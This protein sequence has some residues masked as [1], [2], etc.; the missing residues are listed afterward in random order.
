MTTEA[1]ALRWLAQNTAARP[2]VFLV[3]EVPVDVLRA[4]DRSR[5]VLRLP[6]GIVALKSP[7]DDPDTVIRAVVWSIVEKLTGVYAPAVVERDS[8]VRLHLGRTDPGQEIRLRQTGQTRWQKEIV[9]GLVIRVERGDVTDSTE[10]RIGDARI[11][12][13][14][15]E[16]VLLSLPLNFLRG[17]GLRDVSV[18]LKSLML[19]H[20]AVVNAYR[21]NPRPVVLKRIADIAADVGND[22]L[23]DM[24]S[25]IVSA[26]QNVRIGRD[27]TGIGRELVIPAQVAAMATTNRPWLDRLSLMILESITQIDNV[28]AAAPPSRGGRNLPSLLEEARA[29][30][31]YDAYH[32]S[33]IEGYRL[34]LEE[35]SSLLGGT[36]TGPRIEDLESRLAVIGYSAAF[37][38]LLA[39]MESAGGT[40]KL[41][42][43]LALDLYAD[44][45]IPS[46]EAGLVDS[47]DLRGWRSSPV[48]IRNTMFVPPNADKVPAMIEMLFEQIE[49][50][51]AD[52]GLLRACL[53]HLWFVW[54]HPFPDGNGRVAR[55]LMNAALLGAGEPWLTLR[56]DQRDE[57]FETLRA[58][59]LDEN[60][61]PFGRLILRSAQ[62]TA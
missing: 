33:S 59:Q 13:D 11:P 18:W 27:R 31:A 6:A 51:P 39:R 61:E 50:I 34:R 40:I 7:A 16:Q 21:E 26:E 37:D 56:M 47:A 24:L 53:V 10:V 60:Y 54:I 32:S 3:S 17:E 44:L 46:V 49:R 2:P 29:A 5:L 48:Y 43:S 38:N 36:G 15:A 58:A 1:E 20:P 28:I 45:F 9:P 41:S 14:P 42:G 57:Y 4:L 62:S 55:F 23:S 52:Q 30:R 35:V 12:V 8:A 22:R 25:Q 19:S